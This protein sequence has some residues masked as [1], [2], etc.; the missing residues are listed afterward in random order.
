[1]L[2]VGRGEGEAAKGGSAPHCEAAGP[3]APARTSG[4]LC[5]A[6]ARAGGALPRHTARDWY[7]A[8]HGDSACQCQVP[9]KGFRGFLS[10]LI[11]ILPGR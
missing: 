7:P 4:N 10:C 5:P 3:G 11:L 8:W 1:M 2:T 6:G 9:M